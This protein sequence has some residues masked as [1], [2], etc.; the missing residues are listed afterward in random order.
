M[1]LMS[2]IRGVAV[3]SFLLVST[4]VY[5]QSNPVE[6]RAADFDSN[7]VC[8]T[9]TLLAFSHQEQLPIAIE[10]IDRAS[11]EQPITVKLQ[12]KTV[13]EAL[14][15]I[16]LHGDGYRWRLRSGIIEITNRRGSKYAE[17]VLNKVIPVFKIPEGA[18][19]KMMSVMLWWNLQME[20]DPSLKKGGIASNIPGNSP[21]VKPEI[22]RNRTV[23]DILAYIVVHSQAEG[24]VV[25]GPAK[26]LGYTPYCGL[27]YFVEGETFNTSYQFVLHQVQDNL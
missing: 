17:R 15:S 21:A 4:C 9:E 1:S 6:R 22:L 20:L 3:F 25:A 16:L 23:R 10:Y 13:R 24:W 27:W 18:T 11:M 26:C 5:G 2:T 12:N 14:D 8:L 19:V 7:G